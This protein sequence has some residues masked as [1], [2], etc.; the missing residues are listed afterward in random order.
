ML[1]TRFSHKYS[2]PSRMPTVHPQIASGHEAARIA[3]QEHRRAS[4][5]LRF[6]E[7]A[8][9]VLRRPV[10]LPLRVFLE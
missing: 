1:Q 9:H 7:L 5:L 8:Q 10:S 4:V 6:T 3:Y 2:L